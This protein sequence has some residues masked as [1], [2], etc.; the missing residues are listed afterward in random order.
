MAWA[1]TGCSAY[2]EAM[3]GIWSVVHGFLD[4]QRGGRWLGRLALF[5][6]LL[7]LRVHIQIPCIVKLGNEILNL[8]GEGH[9]DRCC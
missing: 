9:G 6:E 3:A 4:L 7:T 5:E 8:L 2:V 1:R